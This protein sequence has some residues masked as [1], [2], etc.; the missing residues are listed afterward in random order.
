V[1]NIANRVATPP[2]RPVLIYDGDCRFCTLWIRRWQQETGD[3]IEYL[4]SQDATVRERFPEIPTT[5][6][7]AAVQFVETDGRVISGAAAVFRA[8]AR[9]PHQQR[10]WRYY[11]KWPWFASLSEQTYRQVAQHRPFFSKITGLLFGAR[12]ERPDY[13]L[14]RWIFLRALGVIY[15]IA[16]VSLWTQVDGLIGSNGIL[17]ATGFMADARRYF[18]S[19]VIELDRFRQLPTFG[20]LSVSDR[21]LHLQCAA[22]TVLAL[23]LV[24]GIAPAPCLFLLWLIYLSLSGV[25][26]IFL[27]Y[28]WDVLLLETGFLAIFL[29]PIQLWPRLAHQT[30]PS[31]LT[32]WL[33]RLLLFKL[34]FQSGCV[35]L[36]SGDEAWRN[37]TALAVHYET[38]PLPTWIGWY[39]HQLPLWVQKASCF[40]MFG[41]ELVVPFFIF[42]PRR[43]RQLAALLFALLQI[44]ILLTGN[45]T[46]F[47]CVTLALCVTLLDDF[48]LARFLP[49]YLRSRFPHLQPGAAPPW[50][51]NTVVGLAIVIISITTVQLLGMFGIRSV[52][53]AP[54]SELH[55]LLAPFRSV[56]S[57]GLFAVMTKTRP[58]IIVEGSNDGLRWRAFEFKYKPG[59]EKQ[60]PRFVAP[61]QPRLDWQMWFAALG[62]SE[63]NPWLASLGVRLLQGSPEVLALLERNP[64][65]GQPPRF[66]RASVYEYHFTTFAERRRT[67]EWWRREFKGQ[68][69]PVMSLPT[70][71][72]PTGGR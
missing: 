41:I 43:P 19:Q 5:A 8:L 22:G 54:V 44:L 11:V 14:T 7:E 35:K 4:P 9:N 13:F 29:A 71:A 30:P 36:L 63:N 59:R 62:R 69:L 18:D 3:T 39:A 21:S 27:S 1:V 68:Y 6:F 48:T 64:F 16:F 61:H 65:P 12:V 70:E 45:Y 72:N 58:E 31:R 42:L 20:W 66:V 24:V 47:N 23:L 34:M 55:Q 56:N 49:K 46:F 51:R 50:H 60:R 52:L 57:Y 37:L 25:A 15:L 67:G 32:L 53:F 17:P 26:G 38:Q 2:P 28:Q 40:M 33:L 10:W